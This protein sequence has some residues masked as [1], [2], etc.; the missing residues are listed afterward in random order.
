METVACEMSKR[1]AR[2]AQMVCDAMP[3]FA[4]KTAQSP[5]QA[6]AGFD[7]LV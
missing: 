5:G 3:P 7:I 2:G 6:F 4:N 1:D